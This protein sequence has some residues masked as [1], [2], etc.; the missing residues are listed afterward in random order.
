MRL[1]KLWNCRLLLLTWFAFGFAVF[2]SGCADS[3]PRPK[4]G[5]IYNKAA[6]AADHLRN[7][8]IVI[9]GILGSRLVDD[10]TGKLVWGKF[11]RVRFGRRDTSDVASIALPMGEGVAISQLRDAVRSDETLAY[12]KI[13]V[14]GLPLEIEAYGQILTSLGVGGYRDPQHS[15]TGQ[16]DYGTQHFTCFQFD[17]DWRRDIS[18]NA[19][20]LHAF[21]VERRQYIQ[22]EYY[23]RY[24]IA[25]ADLKFDIVAHSMGGLVARYYLRYGPR[26]LP[27]DGSLPPLDWG[28]AQNV[29]RVVLVGTPNAGSVLTIR[30]LVH[31][32]RLAPILPKYPAAV[33]G[34][35]PAIYQLLPRSRH[36]TL[37]DARDG[38]RKLD[39]YDP[40]IWRDMQW[41]LADPNQDG[42]LQK[43][44]P[45][46]K[47][48]ESRLRI[49]LDHQR[50]CLLRARQLHAALDIPA[51]PPAS[52]TL[53]LFAGDAIETPSVE[54][55]NLQSGQIQAVQ[56]AAGDN[57]TTRTSAVMDERTGTSHTAR[58][59]S[60]IHWTSVMFLHSSHRG[61]TSDPLFTDNVLA[62]LLESP[63]PSPM[64]S[65][66]HAQQSILGDQD[67]V[68]PY[69]PGGAASEAMNH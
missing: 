66:P 29:A 27:E 32:H 5:K 22:Q 67:P 60:P 11:D 6:Q 8:V 53:H 13:S 54:A 12:L 9:P 17:Y 45:E 2:G 68:P 31:G 46:V 50:K 40:A 42:V 34:T 19:A 52:V 55:V 56:H 37:V 28:G 61:L 58:R 43:L 38:Q 18:E 44:L 7:P 23:R 69:A 41:G 4:L 57:T 20:R 24:G 36:G 64:L 21:I 25:D 39:L 1:R 49:A 3:Q 35:M 48:R 15:R 65:T 51:E 59:I 33:L 30:D 62:L 14:A 26:P 63:Q 47:D 10:K 16:V